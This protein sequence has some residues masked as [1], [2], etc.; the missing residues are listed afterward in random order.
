MHIITLVTLLF[1]PGTFVAVRYALSSIRNEVDRRL[2]TNDQ[3]FLGAGFYQWPDTDDASD[4]PKYPVWRSEYFFLFAKISFPLMALTLLFW[5]WPYLSRWISRRKTCSVKTPG[6]WICG[7]R[8]HKV[9]DEEAQ[10]ASSCAQGSA[11]T[12]PRWLR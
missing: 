5:A 10:V 1:L 6:Q 9:E 2:T 4:I 3:T 11:K 8:R 7:F 12:L